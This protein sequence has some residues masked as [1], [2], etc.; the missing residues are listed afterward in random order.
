MKVFCRHWVVLLAL[1]TPLSSECAEPNEPVKI[2]STQQKA[3]TAALSEVDSLRGEASSLPDHVA[4]NILLSDELTEA[5][6]KYLKTILSMRGALKRTQESFNQDLDKTSIANSNAFF[7]DISNRYARTERAVDQMTRN[8]IVS[9]KYQVLNAVSYTASVYRG[10]RDRG[11]LTFDLEIDT[12]PQ[13][14][15]VEYRREGEDYTT[16]EDPSNTTIHNLVIASWQIHVE[17]KGYKPA[18]KWHDA[19]TNPDS[20]VVFI[21]EASQ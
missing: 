3:L 6:V 20:K 10:V 7:S 15:L 13:G 4:S 9:V 5:R 8:N 17:L 16:Y 19:A 2:G 21:L 1:T 12:Q 18:E 14:A 11:S